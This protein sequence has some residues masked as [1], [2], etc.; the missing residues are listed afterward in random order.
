MEVF[1]TYLFIND[2]DDGVP[3][4]ADTIWYEGAWWI[5]ASWLKSRTTESRIPE[6]LVRPINS[7]FHEVGD[8]THRFLLN[9]SVPKSVLDGVAHEEYV[10][11]NYPVLS[12]I[13]EPRSIH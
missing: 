13:Q 1:K 3:F 9:H 2:L 11:S 12:G 6:R 8:H 4:L 10:L 5:V 7:R